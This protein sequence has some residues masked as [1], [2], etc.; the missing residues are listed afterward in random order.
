MVPAK[1]PPQTAHSGACEADPCEPDCDGKECGGDG[2]GGNCGF[3]FPGFICNEASQ[4]E[5]QCLPACQGKDCGPDG[6]GGSCGDCKLAEGCSATGQ[7]ITE[8]VPDCANKECGSDGCGGLRLMP[9]GFNCEIRKFNQTMCMPELDDARKRSSSAYPLT[10][11]ASIS[12]GLSEPFWTSVQ[13]STSAINLHRRRCSSRGA[14]VRNPEDRACRWCPRRAPAARR[15][16]VA[17]GAYPRAS[18]VGERARRDGCVV[19]EDV[20]TPEHPL[21]VAETRRI[22]DVGRALFKDVDVA[23]VGGARPMNRTVGHTPS[24]TPQG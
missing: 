22:R 3:C 21:G 11:G 24:P 1:T 12:V 8:C 17:A 7:C 4:C 14:S 20:Q 2:C 10:R 16:R 5:E 6:C 15:T 18:P 19:V 9:A 13:R 23:R